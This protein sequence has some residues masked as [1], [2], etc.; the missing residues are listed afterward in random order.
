MKSL[1]KV[2][3]KTVV[4]LVL[5]FILGVSVA[6]A[7]FL[8]D[9]Y[10][11]Q[12]QFSIKGVRVEVY[13]WIDDVTPPTTLKTTHDYGTLAGGQV[14]Y[15][16]N[17]VVVNTGTEPTTLSFNTG[18]DSSYG[19]IKWEIEW[20]NSPNWQWKDWEQGIADELYYIPGHPGLPFEAGEMLGMRP[21]S[22]TGIETGRIRVTLTVANSMD[23]GPVAPFDVSITATEV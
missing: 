8:F 10:D 11:M 19:T 4:A 2:S 14:A 7:A 6:Y 13:T 9:T 16:E 17:L 15:T 20:F 18:L 12:F 21:A 1:K 5:T 23:Y 22:P 3:K